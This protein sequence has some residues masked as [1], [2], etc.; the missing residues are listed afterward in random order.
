MCGRSPYVN[1]VLT[2]TP[3]SPI[4]EIIYF[5]RGGNTIW[6]L[7]KLNTTSTSTSISTNSIWWKASWVGGQPNRV[8]KVKSI[9]WTRLWLLKVKLSSPTRFPPLLRIATQ[10]RSS[11][12]PPYKAWINI[13]LIL[14]ANE[15]LESCVPILVNQTS[16]E[17]CCPMALINITAFK[18]QH[19]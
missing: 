16:F 8:G 11:Y 3:K 14:K 18:S 19:R 9:W 17:S 10:T 4:W 5:C 12:G 7:W 6:W 1:G 13:T 15:L 2:H